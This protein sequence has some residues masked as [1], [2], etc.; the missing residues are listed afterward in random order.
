MPIYTFLALNSESISSRLKNIVGYFLHGV[1]LKS[2]KFD[3]YLTKKNKTNI[4]ELLKV[5]LNQ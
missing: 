1:K 5:I 2:Y 3:K 4:K